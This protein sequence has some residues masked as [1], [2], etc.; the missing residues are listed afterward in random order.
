MSDVVHQIA[1]RHC[2][3]DDDGTRCGEDI[4]RPAPVARRRENAI[5]VHRVYGTRK[6]R[7][8]PLDP[9]GTDQREG[10]VW[11]RLAEDRE[12]GEDENR[13]AEAARPDDCDMRVRL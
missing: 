6:E 8:E 11:A 1:I 4:R 12:G 7:L 10:S 9:R 13:V 5:N 2:R 3:I